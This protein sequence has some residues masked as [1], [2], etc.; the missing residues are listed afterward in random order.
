MVRRGQGICVPTL[1][2]DVVRPWRL[3]NAAITLI[4]WKKGV[5]FDAKHL[6]QAA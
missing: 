4:V 1:Q 3:L 6:K 5:R 2:G